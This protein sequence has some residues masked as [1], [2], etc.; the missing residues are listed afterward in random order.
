MS[1][2]TTPSAERIHIGFFG[3]RNVGKSSLVNAVTGQDLA[4]VSDVKGT[5]TDPVSKA[6]EILPLGPVVITDTPGFDDDGMLGELRIRKTK[7]T[8]N[9]TDIAVLVIDAV[10]GMNEYDRRLLQLFKEKGIPY[11]IIYNKCDLMTE[12]PESSGNTLYVSAAAGNGIYELKEKLGHI[13]P[14]K[15]N[16]KI[17]GDILTKG[18]KAV[19]VCP[20]DESA[21]KGRIILPQQQTIRDILDADAIA[22]VTKETDLAETLNSLRMPPKIVI[23]DSQALEIVSKIVPEDVPL[24]TFSILMARYKGF[25]KTAVAGISAAKTLKEK[26][27]ILMAEGCTHHRQC[28][29]IGTVKIPRM[30]Q[31]YCNCDL[32][33]E[34]CSGTE[35][36]EDLSG[37]S[38]VI[39]C[40]ACMNTD[41]D[42]LYR[43]KCTVDQGVPF[44]NYGIALA[45]MTGT[46]E[47]TLR[48]F[49]DIHDL[50]V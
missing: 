31:A 10:S 5:T 50:I 6:M 36:P 7:Q 19:L 30:L 43:M 34:S 35:F 48:C 11:L 9:K 27:K 25:L 13:A 42:V 47:R 33:F 26:D 28:N 23:T 15:N 29:D 4:V 45:Q 38:M 18:D 16:R 49:P 21:P 46:L 40:G 3:C 41:S 17:I 37:Y 44:T 8:I 2:N 39:H 22:L 20:I 24:T 32:V 12:I 1:L 14:K